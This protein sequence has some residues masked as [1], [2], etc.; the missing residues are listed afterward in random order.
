M[1]KE[2]ALRLKKKEPIPDFKSIEEEAEF[3]DTHDTADYEDEFRPVKVR[4]AKRLSDGI[5]V[6]LE[7]DTLAALRT[8]AEKQGTVAAVL[9][10]AWITERLRDLPQTGN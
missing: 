7:P 9:A 10:K 4:F 5:T 2:K 3:W 6:Y 1:T 8:A